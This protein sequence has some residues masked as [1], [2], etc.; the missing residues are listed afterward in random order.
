MVAHIDEGYEGLS[1]TLKGVDVRN[2]P[3]NR[4]QDPGTLDEVFIPISL[5]LESTRGIWWIDDLKKL[6]EI[7]SHIARCLTATQVELG[8]SATQIRDLCFE[9]AHVLK[10]LTNLV[11]VETFPQESGSSRALPRYEFQSSFQLTPKFNLV[12]A[13]NTLL[14]D[15]HLQGLIT[16][17]EPDPSLPGNTEVNGRGYHLKINDPDAT[18]SVTWRVTFPQYPHP[19]QPF[20]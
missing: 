8:S 17:F 6:K 5:R 16:I 9:H 13:A 10:D 15:K 1:I 19:A 18:N 20:G 14:G 4:Q 11:S 3:Q 12:Q 7:Q 2:D